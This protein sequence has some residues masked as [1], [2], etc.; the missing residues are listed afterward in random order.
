MATSPRRALQSPNAERR[1]R[2]R[3]LVSTVVAQTS[4]RHQALPI[5]DSRLV[6]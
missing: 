5:R 1:A 4:H 3:T 6:E 2:H